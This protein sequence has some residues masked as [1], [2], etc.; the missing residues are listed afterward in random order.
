LVEQLA[1]QLNG[2][3]MVQPALFAL[4]VFRP[5]SFL[6]SQGLLLCEP[7]L[8]AFY[9][10]QVFEYANLLA[11]GTSVDCVVARLEQDVSARACIGE[12]DNR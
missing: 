12:G 6:A 8:G 9:G 3:G 1:R 2:W 5:L 7:V 11:D 4:E 10:E